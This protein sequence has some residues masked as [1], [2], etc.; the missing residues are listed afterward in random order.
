MTTSTLKNHQDVLDQWVTA[1]NAHDAVGVA[2]L[3]ASDARVIHPAYLQP[4]QGRKPVQDD[5]QAYITALPNVTSE[6]TRV[7]VDGDEAAVEMTIAGVH[8]GP[9]VL[10]TGTL[11]PTGRRLRFPLASFC[12]FDPEG[13]IIEEH[14]YYDTADILRQL[15]G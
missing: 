12:R 2:A 15:T 14:R 13:Q 6:L 3:Y 4:L 1:F 9:L 8:A 10:T 11:P 5:T 7:F